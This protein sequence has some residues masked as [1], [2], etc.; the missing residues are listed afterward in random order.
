MASRSL[1]FF[2]MPDETWAILWTVARQ[3]GYS[4]ILRRYFRGR[5]LEVASSE[6][7]VM[8]DGRAADQAFISGKTPSTELLAETRLINSA[9]NGWVGLEPPGVDRNNLFLAQLGCKTDWWDTD[10]GSI[11]D[12]P[13]SIVV[14]EKIAK[15]FRPHLT[16]P[17]YADSTKYRTIAYSD[18]AVRWV[19]NGGKLAQR[20]GLAG[21]T[22]GVEFRIEP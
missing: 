19:S 12:E 5:F 13:S 10:A 16:R 18:S 21:K 17:D 15:A 14:F 1:V 3:N 22:T 20:V 2:M 4:I 11:R 9:R 8:S 6:T 7:G